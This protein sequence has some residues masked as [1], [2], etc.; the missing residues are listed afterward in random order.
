R[1]HGQPPHIEPD[2]GLN[3]KWPP[4]VIE[5]TQKVDK[6]RILFKRKKG[7]DEVAAELAA[8]TG[9]AVDTLGAPFQAGGLAPALPGGPAAVG[10]APLPEAPAS[11][12]LPAQPRADRAGAARGA[13]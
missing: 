12:T 7:D 1:R 6:R 9:P 5:E 3:K 8:G 2:K 11:G 10:A 4:V 13:S